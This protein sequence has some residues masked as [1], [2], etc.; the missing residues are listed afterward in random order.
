MRKSNSLPAEGRNAHAGAAAPGR[1]GIGRSLRSPGGAHA[2]GG[3]A[4]RRTFLLALA[5]LAL[6]PARQIAADETRRPAPARGPVTGLPLPRF[7]SLKPDRAN[8]RRG[9]AAKYRI[10]W[11]YRRRGLPLEVIGEYGNWRRVRDW[12]GITGWIYAPLLSG[13]RTALAREAV[14]MLSRPDARS[15]LVARIER[16]ALLRLVACRGDWCKVRA[17]G[18][19][20]W[21]PRSAL[22]GVY[23]DEEFD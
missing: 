16:G 17:A 21:V 4:G 15:F 14:K 5:G 13:R 20:G 23:P 10:D 9:P 18:L 12:E 1:G 19:S 7:V 2:D 6:A 8:L 11:V 3:R 22:W